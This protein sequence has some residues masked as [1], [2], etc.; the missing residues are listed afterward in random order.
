M[1]MIR[2]ALDLNEML[3]GLVV[4]VRRVHG[5]ELVLRGR[6]LWLGRMWVFYGLVWLATRVAGGRMA[7]VDERLDLAETWDI[8]GGDE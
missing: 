8:W 5:V 2:V 6:W 1:G 4:R 3:E 7:V